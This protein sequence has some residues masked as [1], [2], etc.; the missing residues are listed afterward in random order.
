MTMR[1]ELPAQFEPPTAAVFAD[2]GYE[3]ANVYAHLQWLIDRLS[4][5]LAVHV[6]RAMR[7]DGTAAHIRQ[8]SER[9][10][11]GDTARMANPPL[12]VKESVEYTPYP[13]LNSRKGSTRSWS[14]E[15]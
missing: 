2:T 14:A 10:V 5:K 13:N 15:E 8:D 3:P 9:I 1:G 7:P 6:V 11:R 12:F 4:P